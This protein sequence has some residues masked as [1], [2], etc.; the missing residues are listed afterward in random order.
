M[1]Y[2][3]Y[4]GVPPRGS[5]LETLFL[6]VHLGRKEAELLATRSLVRGQFASLAKSPEAAKSAYEAYQSYADAMFPFLE[7]AANTTTSDHTR[8]MEHIKYPMQINTQAIR[9]ERAEE[10][11][12]K[13][14]LKFKARNQKR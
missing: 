13:G 10:A 1:W 8:L 3:K 9:R 6:L 7:Q 14:L 5:P 11:K 12:A 2:D 4:P